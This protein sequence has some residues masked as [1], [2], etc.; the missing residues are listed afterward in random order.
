MP[1]LA[2]I[3]P[4]IPTL[5]EHPP[6]GVAWIH[7]I[8]HDG[9]RTMLLLDGRDRNAFTRNGFDWSD[10]YQTILRAAAELRCRSAIVDGEVIVQ[11]A[12]GVSDFEA[13]KSAIRS[14]PERLVFYA[15]DLLY[16]DGED[17]RE[18]SLVERRAK[19][20][21]LIGK[22][23]ASRIQFSEEFADGGAALFQACAEH[24]LEGIVS[25]LATS[26]Y[27]SGRTKAWL[28]T[29]CFTESAFVVIGTDRDRKTGALRALLARADRQGL[30]YA[31]AAFIAL[32]GDQRDYL[33]ARLE[34]LTI[35]RSPLPG[36]HL[37]GTQWAEP[38]LTVKVRYLPGA[39]YLR[40]GTVRAVI[41]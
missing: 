34:R 20:K 40:H 41:D 17:I 15:Y 33:L 19:L 14:Q 36:L 9:Y 7:E 38:R 37:L 11:D 2:F 27:R 3:E 10:R 13:L 39:K 18:Q 12:R 4:Q 26:R 22:N 1:S 21:G 35:G 30:T 28:K 29:K 5:V 23:A 32:C 6:E 25:K 31:G 8:K 24:G 16:L